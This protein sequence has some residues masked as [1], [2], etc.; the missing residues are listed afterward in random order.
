MSEPNN[1]ELTFR[2][3]LRKQWPGMPEHDVLSMAHSASVMGIY[4][5]GPD[6]LEREG[7]PKGRLVDGEIT[8]R[9]IYPGSYHKYK[10]YYPAGFDPET[11]YPFTLFLDGINIYLSDVVKAD[12]ML[13][14]LISD[15][16]I[17]AMIGI[18]LDPGDHGEGMP[19]YSGA[20]TDWNSNR[21]PEYDSVNDNFVRF[22][23][24]EFLPGIEESC[25]LSH[26][27]E[28]RCLCGANSAANAVF[29]AAWHRPD[30][31]RKVICNVGSFVNIRGGNCQPDRIRKSAPK[32]LRVFLQDGKHDLNIIYGDW[33]LGN[34][35]MAS[36]LEYRG[37]DY[38]Y[39]LGDGGHNLE[40]GGAILPE[41]MEWMWRA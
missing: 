36:A 1:V 18:F 16:R 9:T 25:K 11:E 12:N 28:K 30:Q 38:K 24:E 35:T 23:L 5:L 37:Y 21:S 41:T 14:N 3:V 32:P 40:H 8:S 7:T 15:G 2:E 33:V 31:F 10:V 39:V 34:K 22:L 26:D 20:F 19:I 13:D 17:P 29:N 27:P 4:S 6:S